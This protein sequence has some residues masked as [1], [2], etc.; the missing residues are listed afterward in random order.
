MQANVDLTRPLKLMK[1]LNPIRYSSI[2]STSTS[3]TSKSL[4]IQHYNILMS[5]GSLVS[6]KYRNF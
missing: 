1:P 3:D 6:D 2:H 5:H 4:G